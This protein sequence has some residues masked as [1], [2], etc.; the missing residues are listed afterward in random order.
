MRLLTAVGCCLTVAACTVGT[1]ASNYQPARG[2][3]GAMVNLQLLDKS[4]SQGEL[5]AVE[6][7]ALLLLR[8]SQLVRVPLSQVRSG[9]APSVAFNGRMRTETRER[10]R[11]ISR[12]PQGV[13]TELEGRLLTAYGQREVRS[14]P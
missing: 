7:N 5:L 3:A 1:R 6:D 4:R 11:L 9:R 8:D 2:P 12:Y 10:L 14:L 13:S